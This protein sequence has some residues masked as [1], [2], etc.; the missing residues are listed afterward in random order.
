MMD[1]TSNKI[2]FSYRAAQ[3][4]IVSCLL[5]LSGCMGQ[6]TVP[7][8]HYYRL[9]DI[10]PDERMTKPVIEGTLGVELFQLN[11]IPNTRSMLYVESSHP[12]ELKQ[13]HY[14]HWVDSP[15]KLINTSIVTFLKESGVA[16]DV[17]HANDKTPLDNI[18]RGR[19]IRF[20]RIMENSSPKIIVKLA[21]S[22]DSSQGEQPVKSKIYEAVITADN[23]SMDVT[24]TTFSDAL[25]IIYQALLLDILA[26]K[27]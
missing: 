26:A 11:G 3:Y 13:Y 23:K 24:V 9:P 17:K 1:T 15:E 2:N 18:I 27:K 12:N 14:R 8:D 7:E 4:L 6:T 19:I 22:V 25:K 16:D 10:F 21:M 20:E 5:L